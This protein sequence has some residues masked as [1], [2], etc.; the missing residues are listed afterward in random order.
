MLLL[1][2]D[3]L[4]W[5][6]AGLTAATFAC[7]DMRRLRVL[8]LA[9]NLAF[10]AYGLGAGLAPVL[11]LHLVLAPMNLWRLVQLRRAEAAART[12]ARGPARPAAPAQPA[13]PTPAAPDR[14][15]AGA[16]PGIVLRPASPWLRS[17]LRRHCAPRARAVGP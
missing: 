2:A 9:A 3:T 5:L 6:A 15:P 7:T 8:A 11:A 17:P 14:H 4:G 12:T 16:R 1:S 10:I 13:S